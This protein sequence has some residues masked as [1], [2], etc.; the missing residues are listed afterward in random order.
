MVRL[1]GCPHDS[2][3]NLVLRIC[4]PYPPPPPIR[5]YSQRLAQPGRSCLLLVNLVRLLRFTLPWT[6]R[7]GFCD[8]S[9]QM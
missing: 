7:L 3:D 1:E 2:N 4:V 8:R 9:V 5:S 6:W